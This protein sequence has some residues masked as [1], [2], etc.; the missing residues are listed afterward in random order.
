MNCVYAELYFCILVTLNSSNILMIMFLLL[1]LEKS[2]FN[3][4]C[5]TQSWKSL[6]LSVILCDELKN[7]L[8]VYL[9]FL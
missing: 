9:V 7:C 6:Y 8:T 3:L 4:F 2:S 5:V 1:R